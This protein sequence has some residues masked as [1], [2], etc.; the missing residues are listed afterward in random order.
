MK[1]N[2]KK[3][4]ARNRAVIALLLALSAALVLAGCFNPLDPVDS[5]AQTGAGY[6]SVSI[7]GQGGGART[8]YPSAN[9]TKYELTFA[10]D[11]KSYGPKTLTGTASE[12]F[13][14]IPAGTWTIT[15]KGYVTIDGQEYAAAEGSQTVDIEAGKSQSVSIA[16]SAKQ[17]GDPG[18]FYYN[19]SFPHGKV[20]TA[21]LTL[22]QFDSSSGSYN[23]FVSVA[24]PVDLKTSS[25]GY[26]NS[27]AA[28]LTPGYYRVDIVLQNEYQSAGISEVVH[29]YSNMETRAEYAYTEADFVD[30]VTLSGTLTATVN[31]E[32]PS[33]VYIS[34]F[35]EGNWNSIGSTRVDPY[36]AGAPWSMNV[37][38]FSEETTVTFS[39]ELYDSSYNYIGSK[40]DLS[41]TAAHNSAVTNISLN[42]E[43]S[44]VTLSGTIGSVT[45][46]DV[47]LSGFV[48]AA[49]KSD[50]YLG[51]TSNI[52]DGAWSITFSADVKSGDEVSI[53][54]FIEKPDGSSYSKTLATCTY[55]G[56]SISSISLGS[57]VIRTVSGTVA[58]L[59][60]GT[61]GGMVVALSE[62][63]A[64]GSME[65]GE[66]YM[67]D[68]GEIDDN[69]GWSLKVPS[70]APAS[71]WFAV[72]VYDE[73]SQR[74]FVTNAASSDVTV[75]LDINAMTEVE[76]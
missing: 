34:A 67:I 3:D 38:A 50:E 70:D 5:G 7:A 56:S 49:F 42:V 23:N 21:T 72:I 46:D 45:V 41:P 57:V 68:Y 27:G 32:A 53:R 2:M 16:I 6:L 58:N 33:Y 10:S 8:L 63:P 51:Y 75:P 37:P 73:E 18:Y 4:T 17:D 15:A 43:Y 22:S 31:G 62:V 76:L 40:Y 55:N 69:G 13:D 12:S 29:I 47:S 71:L 39:V 66:Q 65:E 44:I 59:P 19:V 20:D 30:F 1:K 24:Q 64:S 54:L 61:M 14:D 26:V 52:E 35:A 36:S 9:F 74:L 25:S 60:A 11:G 28:G 48:L